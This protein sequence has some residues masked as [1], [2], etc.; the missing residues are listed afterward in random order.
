MLKKNLAAL[1]EDI[2]T[3]LR[4]F[5]KLDADTADLENQKSTLEDLRTIIKRVGNQLYLWNIELEAEQRI[6]VVEPATR[7]QGDDAIAKYYWVAFAAVV[8]FCTALLLVM[9]SSGRRWTSVMVSGLLLGGLSASVVWVLLPVHY[10][11]QSLIKVHRIQPVVLQD[12]ANGGIDEGAT[13]DIY[14]KTQLQLLK[15]NFVLARAARCSEMVVLKTMQEHKE[16]PVGFL[17]SNLIVDYPGDAELMRV[18]IKGTHRDELATIVNAVVQSYMDEVVNAEQVVR[19]KQRDLLNQHYSKS[20]EEFRNKSEKYHALI[21]QLGFSNSESARMRRKI[22]EQRLESLV[23]SANALE[24]RIREQEI[25]LLLL[26]ERKAKAGD[27][28][29]ITPD[30]TAGNSA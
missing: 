24:Q 9:L 3:Q 25:Q 17:E 28:A 30:P 1:N 19:L 13:Y 21:N 18:A 23:Q 14:K 27:G 6:K 26:K 29:S 5:G 20:Q 15:S 8:G 7:P 12:V 10:E 4:E 11:A 22:A 2:E 16:D